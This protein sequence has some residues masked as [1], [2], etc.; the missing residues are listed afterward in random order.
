MLFIASDHAGLPLK[1]V[2]CL[3]LKEQK[4]KYEDLGTYT[5]DRVNY[6]D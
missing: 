6:T 1:N 2:V 4:I 5:K 3:Y